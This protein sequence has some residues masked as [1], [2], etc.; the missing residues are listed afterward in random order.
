MCSLQ[1]QWVYYNGGQLKV[2]LWFDLRLFRFSFGNP[3][4]FIYMD[5]HP[6]A[7]STLF[8]LASQAGF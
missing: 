5:G 8:L 7:G 2:N 6:Q 4:V 1:K 3:D